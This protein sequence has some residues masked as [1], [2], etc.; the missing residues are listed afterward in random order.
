MSGLSLSVG[1]ISGIDYV[2][3]VNQ[4]IQL[5]GIS[6][7]NLAAKNQRLEM[8][9]DSLSALLGRFYTA[10]YMIRNLN[11]AL[12]FQR[13]DVTSSNPSL[14]SVVRTGA[15]V[16]GNYTFTPLQMASSQQT[17]ARGVA[18]DTDALGK[19]GTVTIGKGWSVENQNS[20]DLNDL[21]GGH[22]ISKGLIRI[23]DGNGMRA[24]IDLRKANTVKD[25]LDAINENYD[26]DV[27]AELDGD[28]LVLRDVSGG[29]PSK[30]TV[31]EVSGGRT[32]A[33]LGLIG[34]GAAVDDEG[35]LRG[36]AIW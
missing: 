36:N 29:D 10:S 31:N 26:V 15:P 30:M 6:K 20:I 27:I 21:N 17:V 8:E 13:T 7:D 1:L 3:L 16:V 19:T 14:I 12:P 28:R 32:A 35:V 24:T 11:R 22:G 4:L 18:S 34:T 23:T 5:D 9:Y 33:S 25:V 2:S